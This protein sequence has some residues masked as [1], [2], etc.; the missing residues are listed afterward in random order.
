MDSTEIQQVALE[1][2]VALYQGEGTFP[3]L[4]AR[5]QQ[6]DAVLEA[7]TRFARWLGSPVMYL[8]IKPAPLTYVQGSDQAVITA[9]SGGR[10]ELKD[11]QQVSLDVQEKDAKGFATNQAGDIVLTWDT[12]D[13]AVVSLQ[14]AAD[15][16]TCEAVAGNPGSALVTVSDGTNQ[17]SLAVDVTAGPAV[18]IQINAGTPEDQPPAP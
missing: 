5:K 3:N 14:P 15:G 13:S 10:M 4:D 6:I 9:V 16:L 8:S 18:A 11:N 2:A 1:R 12:S 17:G 7:A